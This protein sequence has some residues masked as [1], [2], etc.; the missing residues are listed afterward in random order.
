M[1][2][3]VILFANLLHFLPRW[4]EFTKK[5]YKTAIRR[6][7]NNL[8]PKS[9]GTYVLTLYLDAPYLFSWWALGQASLPARLQCKMNF[10]VITFRR[11]F[12]VV[13]MLRGQ[14]LVL[15]ALFIIVKN[16]QINSLQQDV[17]N[18][19][20]SNMFSTIY[21]EFRVEVKCLY[22]VHTVIPSVSW[23]NPREL[24]KGKYAGNFQIVSLW[25]LKSM[26]VLRTFVYTTFIRR[27]CA[28]NF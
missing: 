14:F 12:P 20:F 6:A 3:F 22:V 26:T 17:L 23:V 2:L 21:C 19:S 15:I 28:L 18:V 9:A 4:G 16:I 8:F 25:S 1:V 27:F 11:E 24:V 10:N 7:V 13:K 5:S